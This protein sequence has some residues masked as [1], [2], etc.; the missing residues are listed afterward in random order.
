MTVLCEY[1]LSNPGCA[2]DHEIFS[3]NEIFDPERV[4]TFY[5]LPAEHR[6]KVKVSDKATN[7]SVV[8]QELLDH[9]YEKM[10]HQRLHQ[11]DPSKWQFKIA[12][13]REVVGFER[14]ADGSRL[15]LR[16][17]DTANGVTTMSESGFDL[18]ILGTGYERK[19]HEKLLEPTRHLLQEDGFAVA[20]DYRVKYREGATRPETGIYLQ[21]CCEDSHGVSS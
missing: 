15:R 7:Y 14:C 20:R 18:V 21:G 12:A 19:R 4:D 2:V 1:G 10:Y 16:L 9:L 8:R 6:Q 3:V 13:W 17:R 11:P 5:E